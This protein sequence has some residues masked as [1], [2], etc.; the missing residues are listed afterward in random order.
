MKKRSFPKKIMNGLEFLKRSYKER[1]MAHCV[2]YSIY[3]TK[4]IK[5]YKI[6]FKKGILHEDNLWTPQ[7]F[8]KAKR[9]MY[10]DLD[11]YM[12][13]Q[14][15]GSITNRKDKT[16]NGIDILSTCY[17][18]AE[19]YKDIK[20]REAKRVLNDVLV[21][22]YLRA[23]CIGNLTSRKYINLIDRK[24]LL[25]K[26]LRIKNKIKVGIFFINPILYVKV[27]SRFYL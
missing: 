26:S 11:F 22:S 1:A 18:L 25:G 4:L 15:E 2:Q 5:D 10:Y 17:E 13:F 3:K 6:M 23:V 24:F 20:D 21:S 16:K 14:R 8:L 27:F 19:I 9:V 12:H 7:V